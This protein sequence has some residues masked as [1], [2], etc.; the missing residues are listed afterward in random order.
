[1][2]TSVPVWPDF[3][4]H[5]G[6]ACRLSRRCGGFPCR[7]GFSFHWFANLFLKRTLPTWLRIIRDI[8]SSMTSSRPRITIHSSC[9]STHRV[10]DRTLLSFAGCFKPTKFVRPKTFDDVSSINTPSQRRRVE[11][12]AVFALSR[13]HRMSIEGEVGTT[14]TLQSRRYVDLEHAKPLSPRMGARNEQILIIPK[15]PQRVKRMK[16]EKKELF[17]M[18]GAF[19][20]LV[21]KFG[22]CRERRIVAKKRFGNTS[23]A[24]HQSVITECRKTK[25]QKTGL[26]CSH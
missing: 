15:D 4:D 5:H 7:L 6:S 3:L 2:P 18:G 10:V 19:L 1:M 25:V 12:R 8:V 16:N 22:D 14:P 9:E 21:T 23:R 26:H 17:A 20:K 24:F 13:I 11:E